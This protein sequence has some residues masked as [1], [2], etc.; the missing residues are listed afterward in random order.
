MWTEAL[1]LIRKSLNALPTFLTALEDLV[2][3]QMVLNDRGAAEYALEQLKL[4]GKD[5]SRANDAAQRLGAQ[6][7]KMPWK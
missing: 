1:L 7:E 6:I 3:I 4:L 2:Y 5:V